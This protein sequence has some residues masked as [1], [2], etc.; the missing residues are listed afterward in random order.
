MF[1]NLSLVTTSL[2]K[3]L[4]SNL[5]VVCAHRIS[6]DLAPLVNFPNPMMIIR[7]M[8]GSVQNTLTGVFMA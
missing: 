1:W 8:L 5:S 4:E 6:F 3:Q 2:F 7:F